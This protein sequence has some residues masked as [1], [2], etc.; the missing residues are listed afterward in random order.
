[1]CRRL[2]S[3]SVMT[4]QPTVMR[5]LGIIAAS[6][7]T[8]SSDFAAP[9]AC[10]NGRPLRT[11]TQCLRAM[12]HAVRSS[13]NLLEDD[14]HCQYDRAAVKGISCRTVRLSQQGVDLVS[15]I[16]EQVR[17]RVPDVLAQVDNVGCDPLRNLLDR[18]LLCIQ[19]GDI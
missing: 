12:Q 1:M 9:G 2:K 17:S 13:K 8:P 3:S 7:F 4:A 14:N 6:G 5:S 15:E 10:L 16:D 11:L 18:A 19:Y